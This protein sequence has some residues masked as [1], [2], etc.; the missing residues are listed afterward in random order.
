MPI[1]R[2]LTESRTVVMIAHDQRLGA[3]ADRTAI[4]KGGRAT[5]TSP[6]WAEHV[7]ELA[8]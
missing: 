2:R 3:L 6:D 7:A 8:A 4:R 1:L 5:T